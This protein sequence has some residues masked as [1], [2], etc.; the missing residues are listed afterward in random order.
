MEGFYWP[1]TAPLATIATTNA[2]LT[3]LVTTKR[4]TATTVDMWMDPRNRQQP[5]DVQPR[6]VADELVGIIGR[7]RVTGTTVSFIAVPEGSQ[8]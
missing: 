5:A 1:G 3:A 8:S 7:R 4:N 2:A 6:A